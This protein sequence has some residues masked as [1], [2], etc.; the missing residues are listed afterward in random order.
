MTK[1]EE[2]KIVVVDS[3]EIG[4]TVMAEALMQHIARDIEITFLTPLELS[5]ETGALYSP[6]IHPLVLSAPYASM[7]VPLSRRD[8]RKKNRKKKRN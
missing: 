4:K 7:R 3:G 5:E 6:P 2:L 8:K 1:Q